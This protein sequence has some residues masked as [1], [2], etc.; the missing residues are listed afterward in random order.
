[1]TRELDKLPIH[2]V[3]MHVCPKTQ[4]CLYVGHGRFERAWRCSTS[5]NQKL[6]GHRCKEHSEYLMQL[7]L[8]GFI[9]YDWCT[10]IYTRLDKKRA[11]QLEQEET[12]SREPKYNKPLGLTLM[13]IK[14]EEL[15]LIREMREQGMFYSEIANKTKRTTM[16]V[17]RAI[18]GKHKNKL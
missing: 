9:P 17:W 16:T 2:Y 5:G 15:K 4:E 3:Y 7:Q 6:Y 14:G 11:C 10:I 12:R 13:K 18:N 1:M 8:E